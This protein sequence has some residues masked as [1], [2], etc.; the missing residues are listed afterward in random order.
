MKMVID[1]LR[2][3]RGIKQPLTWAGE[4]ELQKEI[5]CAW[6][7]PPQQDSTAA[8]KQAEFTKRSPMADVHPGMKTQDS[9]SNS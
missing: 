8:F 5:C 7:K 1:C 9:C 4:G 3:V 2:V 6:S